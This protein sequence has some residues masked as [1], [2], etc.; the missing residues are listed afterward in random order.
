MSSENGSTEKS[1]TKPEL[2]KIWWYWFKYCL[3]VFGYERLQ[4]PGFTLA[5]TPVFDKYYS[6]NEDEMQAAL[7]RHT[8]F[9]NTNIPFG[10]VI[11]GIV[12][13]LEE[14]RAKGADVS[15]E[16][17]NNI[18]V[19]LMG[20]LAG[21]GDAITQAT[22]PPILLSIGIGLAAGGNPLGAVF[23]VLAYTVFNVVV[24]YTVLMQGYHMGTNAV[25]FFLGEKMAK[26]QEAM[27]VL[28]LTV[29]GAITA[30][31]IKC[32]LK[33]EYVSEFSTVNFQ[34][35]LDGIFPKMIPI[36]LTLL[37]FYLLKF[38]KF[39]AVKL[40]GVYIVIAVVGGLF[41]II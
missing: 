29:V 4:A 13:S 34:G 25:S 11:V 40:I 32:T 31:Y 33:L 30:S 14:A 6:N 9:F 3:C 17:I 12:A 41:G 7:Q 16:F 8:V 24:S 23:F 1:L 38:K 19:G 20:P 2:R 15:D 5:M 27:S 26:I 21:I 39:T 28:G 22:V 35:V 18:K 10:A 37:G 36:A